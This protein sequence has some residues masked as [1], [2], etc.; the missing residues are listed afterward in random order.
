MGREASEDRLKNKAGGERKKNNIL[1][2]GMEERRD[3]GCHDIRGVV[4]KFLKEKTRNITQKHQLCSKA[5]KK[6]R[7]MTN[8]SEI[9]I[10]LGETRSAKK[11]ET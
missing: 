2:F 8:F 10:L 4:I 3:V 6:E 7:S 11:L 9:Y 1:I 5:E